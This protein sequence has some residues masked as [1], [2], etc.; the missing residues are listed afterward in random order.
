MLEQSSKISNHISSF[1]KYFYSNKKKIS[2]NGYEGSLNLG[3]VILRMQN[4][5]TKKEI[6]SF[7]NSIDQLIYRQWIQKELQ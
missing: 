4:K 7:I 3:R 6:Y 2:Q 5:K 1:N